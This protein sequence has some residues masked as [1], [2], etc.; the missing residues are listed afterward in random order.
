MSLTQEIELLKYKQSNL[1]RLVISHTW[2]MLTEISE[3]SQILVQRLIRSLK[4]ICKYFHQ[5][6]Q[7]QYMKLNCHFIQQL[8]RKDIGLVFA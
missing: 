6:T 5:G 2:Y 1:I 8:S 3:W 4:L 7:R